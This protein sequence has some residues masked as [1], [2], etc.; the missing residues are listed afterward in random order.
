[1]LK[2]YFIEEIEKRRVVQAE[3]DDGQSPAMPAPDDTGCL[4][5]ADSSYG[6]PAGVEEELPSLPAPGSIEPLQPEQFPA[7][8]SSGSIWG[9]VTAALG[10]PR[11]L[12]RGARYR[13]I[14]E[15]ITIVRRQEE[16]R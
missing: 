11:K 8:N 15:R 3:L 5:P 14:T 7:A 2:K 6:S 16:W 13:C 4:A 9:W 12:I 10:E 1:M